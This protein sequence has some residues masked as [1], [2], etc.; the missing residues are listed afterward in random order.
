MLLGLAALIQLSLCMRSA[1]D[2]GCVK[3][4]TSAKCRK[5]N[6]QATHRNSSPQYDLTFRCAIA[7]RCFY[8]CGEYRSFH[9]AETHLRHWLVAHRGPSHWAGLETRYEITKNWALL[10]ARTGRAN[11]R[12]FSFRHGCQERA[13]GWCH[14]VST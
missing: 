9:T 3:T 12:K 11:R 10:L 8:V 6:S 1:Y 2:P 14:P 13:F 4:H 5:N 7:A